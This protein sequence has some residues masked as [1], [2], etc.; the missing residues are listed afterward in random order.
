MLEAGAVREHNE[1]ADK[2][3]LHDKKV[4]RKSYDMLDAQKITNEKPS[5]IDYD[6][7]QKN[8]E[9]YLE[10]QR[11]VLKIGTDNQDRGEL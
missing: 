3:A 9:K 8:A 4:R 7:I 5:D 1:F 11:H 10:Q 6:I 2:A